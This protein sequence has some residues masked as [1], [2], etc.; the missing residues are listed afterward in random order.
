MRVL[1]LLVALT[2]CTELNCS[3]GIKPIVIS[4]SEAAK[5]RPDGLIITYTCLD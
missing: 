1:V 2:G 4:V 5:A 3:A